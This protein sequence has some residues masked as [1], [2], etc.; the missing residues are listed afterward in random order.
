MFHL[1]HK[2]TD[3]E[4]LIKK[5]FVQ[6]KNMPYNTSGFFGL[7]LL[8]NPTHVDLIIQGRKAGVFQPH[9]MIICHYLC[10]GSGLPQPVTDGC[11]CVYGSATL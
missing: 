11:A 8:P 9:G 6:A 1:K 7:L 5:K 4:R 2:S 3:I 10:G